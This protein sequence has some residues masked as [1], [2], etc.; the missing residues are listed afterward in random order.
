MQINFYDNLD[1]SLLG[2]EYRDVSALWLTSTRPEAAA[3]KKAKGAKSGGDVENT[4][5]IDLRRL[6]HLR[7]Q[8]TISCRFLPRKTP[9]SK[10]DARNKLREAMLEE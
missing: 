6:P 3:R 1:G 4:I 10:L 9:S 5:N 8:V 2:C 7:G